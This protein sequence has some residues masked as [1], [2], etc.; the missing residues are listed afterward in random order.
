MLDKLYVYT[1][2]ASRNNPGEA[3]IGIVIFDKKESV[4]PIDKYKDRIGKSTNNQAEYNAL[5][6]GLELASKLCKKEIFCFADSRLVVNQMKGEWK[7]KKKE[8]K[9]LNEKA[10]KLEKMFEKVTY[11]NLPREHPKIKMA[12]KLANEALDE[13]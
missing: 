4:N 10:K 5:I 1:D 12:D 9:L 13:K 3:S 11:T 2:G 7:V 8:L 6:K